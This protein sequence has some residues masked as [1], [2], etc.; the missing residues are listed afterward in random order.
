MIFEIYITGAV[1]LCKDEFQC[2]RRTAK[3]WKK[4][5]MIVFQKKLKSLPTNLEFSDISVLIE[6]NTDLTALHCFNET[7]LQ[8]YAGNRLHV[9]NHSPLLYPLLSQWFL[10]YTELLLF[11]LIVI[12]QRHRK[13][14]LRLGFGQGHMHPIVTYATPPRHTDL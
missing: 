2:D 13:P 10:K 12:N 5:G 6:H 9:E 14:M 11:I 7:G 3:N 4:S 1:L 8:N